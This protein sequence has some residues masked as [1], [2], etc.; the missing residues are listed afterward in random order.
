MHIGHGALIY[1]IQKKIHLFLFGEGG[2]A[3]GKAPDRGQDRSVD[4]KVMVDKGPKVLASTV[5]GTRCPRP[6]YIV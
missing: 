5:H 6:K 2:H 3:V 4:Y 1:I